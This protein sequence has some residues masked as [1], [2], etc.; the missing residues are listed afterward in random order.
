MRGEDMMRKYF[1]V[2]LVLFGLLLAGC[3]RLDAGTI[4]EKQFEPAHSTVGNTAVMYARTIHLVPRVVSIPDRWYVTVEGELRDLRHGVERVRVLREE[5][6]H[7]SALYDTVN[8]GD[9][10]RKKDEGVGGCVKH[11]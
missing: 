1:G 9:M 8:L 11:E 2:L 3:S 10:I 4:I 7:S 5:W 6:V